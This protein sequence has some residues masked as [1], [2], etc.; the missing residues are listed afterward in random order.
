MEYSLPGVSGSD[1]L[2]RALPVDRGPDGPE[3][4]PLS[5]VTKVRAA[6]PEEAGAIGRARLSQQCRDA[7]LPEPAIRRAM[8]WATG[9][10]GRREPPV[11]LA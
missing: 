4:I 8:A 7:G 5:F 9:R 6:G 3:P 1:A 10:T 2:A 11:R